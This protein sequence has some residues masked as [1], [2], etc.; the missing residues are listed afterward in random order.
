M[1]LH[2]F[3]NLDPILLIFV[4]QVEQQR[5]LLKFPLVLGDI[6]DK[7]LDE[8]VYSLSLFS[9]LLGLLVITLLL[10]PILL[11][12]LL[13][14]LLTLTFAFFPS[15]AL[16]LLLLV[17]LKLVIDTDFLEIVVGQQKREIVLTEAPN[18]ENILILFLG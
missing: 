18:A 3:M 13:V 6:R 4:N 9:L 5:G 17:Q 10:L 12:L 1:F 8:S 11:G 14:V 7:S 15:S 2:D 16:T